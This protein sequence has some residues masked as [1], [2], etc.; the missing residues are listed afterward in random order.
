MIPS[1]LNHTVLFCVILLFPFYNSLFSQTL[2]RSEKESVSF[3]SAV[4]YIYKGRKFGLEKKFDSATYYIIKGKRI[5]ELNNIIELKTYANLYQSRIA[6]WKGDIK[7][8]KYILENNQ[9]TPV[10]D[11]IAIFTNILF[12]EINDYE[13]NHVAAIQYFIKAQ[14]QLLNLPSLTKKDS[15]LLRQTYSTTGF[16]HEE[17]QN[18]EKA[19]YY[20]TKALDF[21]RDSNDRSYFLFRISSLFKTEKNTTLELKYLKEATNIAEKNKWQLMLPTYYSSLSSYYIKEEKADSA[22]FY[23]DKG[24]HN[25]T[26]CR[27]NWL[28]AHKGEAYFLNKDYKNATFFFNKALE[29][30]TPEETLAVYKN[31]RE[32][33][34]ETKQYEL[35][36]EN[37]TKFLHLKD[38]LDK[39]KVQQEIFEISEKYESKNKE[40][41]I[42]KQSEKLSAYSIGFVIAILIITV[43][44]FYYRKQKKQKHLLYLKN[45][46]LAQ[47]LQKESVTKSIKET[48]I[49]EDTKIDEIQNTILDLIDSESYLSKDITLVK[50]AKLAN[51]NTT[52]LSRV[53]NET[54]NKTFSNFIN[55][56]RIA[57]TL[58]QLEVVPNYR[59]L[60]IDHISDKAG[61]SSNSAFYSA[62]KKFT[63]LTPS[64]YIK[65]HIKENV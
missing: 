43:L 56:L 29:F 8:A 60:T 35:A 49:I 58:K 1:K 62:F 10:N 23:A 13:K 53:I 42:K 32:L 57:F 44:A 9:K 38:S 4:D 14:K 48:I 16:I 24:L 25:N 64:Y 31:L 65:K 26:Y 47:K 36:L 61:F 20:L 15:S 51:T 28:N 54:Y 18:L 37:N 19:Q 21:V 22:I 45:H 12:G 30:T 50:M 59:N 39:L 11:S 52:Y 34:T 63:G 55:D 3:K 46:S 33:Y 27:L 6:Y 17:L 41:T 2:Q 7:R 40:I 5:A